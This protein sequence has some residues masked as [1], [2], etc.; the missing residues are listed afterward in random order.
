MVGAGPV[1]TV[2][3]AH[4]KSLDRRVAIKFL[5]PKHQAHPN[6][7]KHFRQ[8]ARDMAAVSTAC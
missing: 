6:R 8:E 1:G 5:H 4:D 2:Y 3:R 7:V